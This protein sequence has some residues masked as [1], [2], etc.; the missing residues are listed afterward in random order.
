M[1]RSTTSG[2]STSSARLENRVSTAVPTEGRIQDKSDVRRLRQHDR[3]GLRGPRPAQGRQ[4]A[5]DAGPRLPAPAAVRPGLLPAELQRR[6][7]RR[8]PGLHGPGRSADTDVTA[9][10][11]VELWSIRD[12]SPELRASLSAAVA[13]LRTQ[14]HD[15]GS[16]GGGP[17]TSAA[18]SNSTGLAAWA[19]GLAGRCAV[20][21]KA[22]GWVPQPAG[23]GPA[24]RL[25]RWPASAAR[26]PTTTPR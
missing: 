11:V 8:R 21:G 1:R 3:P 26:S 18:N 24:G 25:R 19:L 7:D 10:A 22:A 4:H 16:F 6:Q 13:W 14:Q 20:A 15:N 23:A 17:T 12:T 9:L 2:E 5:G